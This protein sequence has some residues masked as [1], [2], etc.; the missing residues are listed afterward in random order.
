MNTFL[1]PLIDPLFKGYPAHAPALRRSQIGEQ[2]WHVLADQLPLPLAVV[3]RDALTHNLSWMQRLV[4]EAGIALAPHGKTTMSPQLFKAQLAAGAWGITFA[5]VH[6]LTIGVASG[7]RRAVIANQL[8]QKA[9]LAALA[10]LQR[11]APDLRV[12]FLVDSTEQLDRI[13]QADQSIAFE[14]LVELGLPNGRT[15][16]RTDEEALALARRLHAS[17][18]VRLA[19]VEVYEGLWAK[20]E[21]TEDAALVNGLMQRLHRFVAACD[22]E[23]LFDVPEILVSAGGSAVFDLVARGLRGAESPRP[24]QALLRS[25]CYVTHDDGAYQRYAQAVNRR[26]GC[27]DASG[28]RAALEVW[29]V[30]QSCPEP[31]LVILN[32]GKRDVSTDWGLPVPTKLARAGER[33]ASKAP[34]A[35]AV[36]KLNDQHCYL[37]LNDA[38]LDLRVGDR[39]AL[40]ISHPCTTFDKWRWMA[41]VDEDYRVV[42]ALTTH[43]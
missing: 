17:P 20:G 41:V 19:G 26:L 8:V 6:Q 38:G 4:N 3:H 12:A 25:G 37:R 32:A 11:Q 42:D 9:E 28:L 43:F 15:G 24:M 13:E 5:N 22:A 1:D 14:V 18:C 27:S 34:T 2:G 30:V 36:D 35:W 33:R 7:V 31:G 39:V 16:A 21:D 29:T 10:A 40:G 23:K